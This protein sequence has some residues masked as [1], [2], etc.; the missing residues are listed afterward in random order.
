MATGSYKNWYSL[1]S[2]RPI[3]TAI[4]YQLLK[5]KGMSEPRTGE[6]NG[7]ISNKKH[8]IF[9]K[10]VLPPVAGMAGNKILDDK[11]LNSKEIPTPT[12][13]YAYFPRCCITV[14]G[15]SIT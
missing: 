13:Y 8:I 1:F 6:C 7:A 15:L 2:Y 12:A 11:F 14:Y 10:L 9:I 5:I 3:G 4:L